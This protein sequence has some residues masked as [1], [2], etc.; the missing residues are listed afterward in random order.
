MWPAI[1]NR[2]GP[3]LLQDRAPPHTSKLTGQ[4]LTPLGIEVLP[5]PP[6]SPDLSP[7]DYFFRALDANLREQ[8]FPDVENVEIASQNFLKSCYLN[9]YSKGMNS[10]HYR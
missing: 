6:H 5:H 1:V 2:S 7:T 3:L 8:Q 9:L 10:S 4:K